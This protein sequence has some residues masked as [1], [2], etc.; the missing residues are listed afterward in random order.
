MM[1]TVAD[2][3]AA[4]GSVG[5]PSTHLLWRAGE[6]PPLPYAVLVPHESRNTYSDNRVG[7]RA[8]A[9]DIELY[10]H[11]RDVALERRVSRALDAAGVVHTSDVA[12]DESGRVV[13]T[14]FST[15]LTEQEAS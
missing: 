1:P 9:Y 5:L 2:A 8:R 7:L 13:I 14:Y 11:E 10:S 15:T 4:L 3:L 12:T 6:A